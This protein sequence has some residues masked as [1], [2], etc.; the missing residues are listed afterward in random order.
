MIVI[1]RGN[2]INIF[3]IELEV[4]KFKCFHIYDKNINNDKNC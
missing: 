3:F 4:S 2:I 1:F